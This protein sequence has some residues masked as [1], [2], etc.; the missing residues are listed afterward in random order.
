[1]FYNGAW[2]KV[3]DDNW[4][5]EDANVVCRQL[6]L[7]PAQSAPCCGI[8]GSGSGSYVLDEV[9]CRGYENSLDQCSSQGWGNHDCYTGEEAGVVC[10]AFPSSPSPSPINPSPSPTQPSESPCES[11]QPSPVASSVLVSSS[12][13]VGK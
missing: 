11:I 12:V 6:G 8:F 2:G 7:P 1:V 4:S 13:N 10:R 3:C 9:R 5:M